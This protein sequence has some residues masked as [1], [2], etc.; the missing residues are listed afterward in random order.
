MKK[1]NLLSLEHG[2]QALERH[3]LHLKFLLNSVTAG[4]GPL[5]C[6]THQFV[7]DIDIRLFKVNRNAT[8]LHVYDGFGAI[9]AKLSWLSRDGRSQ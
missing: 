6:A 2:S 5:V 1:P 9:F 4:I 7:N 3:W 8:E